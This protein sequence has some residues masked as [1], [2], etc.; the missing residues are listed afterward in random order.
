VIALFYFGLLVVLFFAVNYGLI[1]KNMPC[2]VIAAIGH[3][4]PLV[5]FSIESG[6]TKYEYESYVYA[7]IIF[8]FLFIGCIF[9]ARCWGKFVREVRDIHLRE[10]KVFKKSVRYTDLIKATKDLKQSQ[11]QIGVGNNNRSIDDEPFL[12]VRS[13]LKY[14]TQQH[15][16]LMDG[17][18]DGNRFRNMGE[19]L[20]EY[21]FNNIDDPEKED[22]IFD[23]VWETEQK[24]LCVQFKSN[25]LIFE[26]YSTSTSIVKPL[27]SDSGVYVVNVIVWIVFWPNYLFIN[28]FNSK[29]FTD[30]FHNN[31]ICFFDRISD[32]NWD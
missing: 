7:G 31:I 6:L 21:I 17:I 3:I 26:D 29:N 12:E 11:L 27:I 15:Y 13:K 19:H 24:N 25:I 14:V 28:S 30:W 10:K 1:K 23:I 32:S 18:F 5:Y 4:V 20:Y 22:K 2:I 8:V 9:S 16:K